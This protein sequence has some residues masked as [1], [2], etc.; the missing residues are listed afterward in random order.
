MLKTNPDNP[1]R[2]DRNNLYA[3]ELF[4][5]FNTVPGVARYTLQP[6]DYRGCQSL[7]RLYLEAM[8][9][10]EYLFATQ[11]FD[12][13]EH[14]RQLSET[15]WLSPY[16]EQWRRELALKVEA[17]ALAKLIATATGDTKDSFQAQKAV[18]DR[19]KTKARVGRPN[20]EVLETAAEIAGNDRLEEDFERIMGLA[21]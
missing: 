9:V 20:K 4:V 15:K 8:D 2:N 13:W 3:K 1:F 12:G 11:Y 7:K 21:N 19:Y 18:L 6:H 5:E 16:V 17:T 10:T 14:W